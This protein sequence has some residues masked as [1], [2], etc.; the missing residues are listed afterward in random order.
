MTD[1]N[2]EGFD[3]KGQYNDQ[4]LKHTDCHGHTYFILIFLYF[5]RIYSVKYLSPYH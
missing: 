1:H 2:E 5:I 3:T 4:D